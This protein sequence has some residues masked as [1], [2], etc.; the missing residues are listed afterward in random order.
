MKSSIVL[1]IFATILLSLSSASARCSNIP[2]G[3]FISSPESERMWFMC[4]GGEKIY[5][6]WCDDDEIFYPAT[7]SCNY[8]ITC[9]DAFNGVKLNY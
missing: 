8:E 6:G 2:D 4:S 7:Q 3:M 1:K 5:E 9:D